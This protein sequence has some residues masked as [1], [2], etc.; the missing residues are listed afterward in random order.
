MAKKPTR[1]PIA[2]AVALSLGTTTVYAAPGTDTS[3]EDRLA[4]LEARVAAAEARAQK[5][6]ATVEQLTTSQQT[7]SSETRSLGDSSAP[8]APSVGPAG[9]APSMEQRVAKLEGNADKKLG[10]TLNGYARAG[11]LFDDELTGTEGGPYIT[12]A[13]SVGGAVGRLG[14]EDD[15]YAEI[16]LEHRAEYENG[17]TSLYKIMLADGVESSNDWTGGDSSL[18][19]RQIFAEFGSLPDFGGPLENASIWAGKRFDRDN[20]DIHWLDSDVVFLAGT[21]AGIYDIKVADDWTS[22]VSIYGRDY[23]YIGDEGFGDEVESY[24]F[25]LNNRIGNWQWMLNGLSAKNNDDRELDPGML[26]PDPRADLAEHGAHTMVAYHGESFFGLRD[27]TYKAAVLYGQGLGAEVKSLG[28]DGNLTEDAESVRLAVYGTTYLTPSWRFAP[29]LLAEHSKDRYVSGDSYKWLTLNAR[30][31]NELSE[32]FEMQ[33]EVSWQTMDLDP[34]GYN[35]FNSVDGDYT[36]FTIAPTFKPQVGGFWV[37][38]EIR[39][40]ATYADWDSDLNNY[41]SG[42]SDVKSLG[43]NGYTGGEWSFGTQMEMWF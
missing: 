20:F 13:G 5:A 15:N 28:S 7:A 22:N 23:G 24:I 11:L 14:N 18:N 34:Q 25:T 33:Y 31:A 4:A 19:V 9:D 43:T 6:E 12:P 38:P 37:R 36:K 39:L 10:L 32:N 29:S 1:T 17:S 35:S 3:I 16:V 40:F 21:G 26:P 41:A 8:S 42:N 2:L 30:V 27:G